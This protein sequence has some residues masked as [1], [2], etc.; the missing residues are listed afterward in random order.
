[1]PPLWATSNPDRFGMPHY[2]LTMPLD[3]QPCINAK[4]GTL[5]DELLLPNVICTTPS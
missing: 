3:R 5:L 1:M 4:V 2:F